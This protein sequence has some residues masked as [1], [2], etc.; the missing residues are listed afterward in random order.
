MSNPIFGPNKFKLGTFGTNGKGT[1]LT[2]APDAHRPSW[3]T[4]VE[5]AKMCD[6]AGFEAMLAYARW[7]PFVPG[8]FD[9]ASGV[10]LDPFAWAAGLSQVTKYSAIIATTHAPTI[11]P[12]VAAKQCA[13]IDIM[14]NGRFGLNVVGGWNKPE[15]DMFGQPLADHE[16]RYDYLEEWL[17]VLERLWSATGEFDFEGRFLKLD[18]AMSMPQPIQRP[19]P[20]IINAGGSERGRRFACQHADMCFVNIHEESPEKARSEVQSYKRMA[21]KEFGRE[22]SVWTMVTVIQGDTRQEAEDYYDYFAVEHEDTVGVDSWMKFALPGK[23]LSEEEI[24]RRRKRIAAGISGDVFV[25]TADDI[26]NGIKAMSDLGV[27]GCLLSWNSF[28]K[29][30]P[31]FIEEVIPRLERMGLR[32]PFNYD[33]V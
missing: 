17:E 10:V 16:G 22:V 11:H 33:A 1:G 23:G 6:R 32:E 4:N 14:S 26:A 8:A 24:R 30:L 25:G 20:P 21:R 19:R 28:A 31:P 13:T 15:F 29:G 5:I 12:I 3:D 2:L 27:D 7:K 18:G 9:H